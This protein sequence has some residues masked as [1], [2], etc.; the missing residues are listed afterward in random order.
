MGWSVDFRINA[1]DYQLQY[2]RGLLVA[3][4]DPAGEAKVL[5]PKEGISAGDPISEL[6]TAILQDLA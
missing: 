3:I 2:D 5:G 6:T 4:K 1:T